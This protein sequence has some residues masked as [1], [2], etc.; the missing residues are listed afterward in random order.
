MEHFNI[1]VSQT[2]NQNIVKFIANSLLTGANS[3][4][5]RNIDEAES[6]PL[7]QQL[8]YLPFVKTVYISQN[9][10]A[11]EK[12]NI[13]EWEDV[14]MEVAESIQ[15]YLNSGKKVISEKKVAKKNPITIYAESTPNP[16]VMKFIANK[17]LVQ[18]IFEFKDV[19]E[20][21]NSPLAAALFKFPFVKEVFISGNFVSVTIFSWAEWQEISMELRE[22]IQRYLEEGKP[23]LTE[24]LRTPTTEQNLKEPSDKTFTAFEKEII[25]ILEEYVTPAVASD[26]GHIHLD[27]FNPETQTVKVILQGACSGCPSSTLTLKNGIETLLKQM[28]PGKIE[29]VVAING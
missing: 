25:S 20:T 18:G 23:V 3:H 12:Y 22:F 29:N 11:I 8:F 19:A 28:I 21:H 7:A 6:S 9:F 17:S 4:E 2:S 14:Q 27:S 26:G 16:G 5:F 1:E 10:V 15:E 13:V 24:D